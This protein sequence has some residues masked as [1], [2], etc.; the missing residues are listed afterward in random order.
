MRI[1]LL[2]ITLTFNA[3]YPAIAAGSPCASMSIK[4]PDTTS[5]SQHKHKHTCHQPAA[6]THATPCHCCDNDAPNALHLTSCDAGCCAGSMVSSMPF[7]MTALLSLSYPVSLKPSRAFVSFHTRS[8]SPELQ[9]PL[10]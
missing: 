5:T 10:V 3:I 6:N 8:I 9:P 2:L 4:A 7:N 1:L